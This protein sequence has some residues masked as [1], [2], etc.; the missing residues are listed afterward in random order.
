MFTFHFKQLSTETCF[1]GVRRIKTT[2]FAVVSLFWFATVLPAAVQILLVEARGLELSDIGIIFGVYGLVIV[3]L[4]VPTGGLA[5]AVGRKRMTLLALLFTLVSETVLLFAF[6]LPMF[7]LF[8]VISGMGRALISGAPEAWFIDS[9]QAS[10]PEVD[11]QPAL[12]QAGTFELFALAAGTLLG[13]FLPMLFT[14]LPAEGTAVLTPF[15]VTIV[16]SGAM[17]IVTFLVVLVFMKEQRPDDSE[18]VAGFRAL[19]E[20]ISTAFDLSRRNPVILLLFGAMFAGGLALSSLEIFWQ[21][22]FAR[23]LGAVEGNSFVFGVLLAGSFGLAMVGNLLSIPL[24]RL[25]NKR[26]AVVAAVFQTLQGGFLIL[27]ALQGLPVAAGAFFWLVYF[28]RG[29]INSPHAT[30]FNAEVPA[31]RRSSM[32]SIQSLVFSAGAVVGSAGLGFVAE[33]SSIGT[34]WTVAGSALLVSVV[35]YVVISVRNPPERTTS[36]A[37]D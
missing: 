1:M 8:A 9:L 16:A 37:V 30:L 36:K 25:L 35:C 15:S 21:P 17:F 10:D 2:Y 24:S 12:A 32:L 18:E 22:N 19:P 23:L 14:N 27:L 3:L 20:V 4:E 26:Y 33:R 7:L 34:A 6:S 31:A 5:D 13:G 11:V 29:V 28:S